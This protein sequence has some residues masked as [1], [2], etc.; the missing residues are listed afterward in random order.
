MVVSSCCLDIEILTT[1]ARWGKRGGETGAMLA[2]LPGKGTGREIQH[3]K[4]DVIRMKD[5]GY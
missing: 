2:K 5:I 1:P 4:R 3:Y